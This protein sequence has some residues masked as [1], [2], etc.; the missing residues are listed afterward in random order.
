MNQR[1]LDEIEHLARQ[2]ETTIPGTRADFERIPSGGGW[3]DVHQNGRL[4]QL[5]YSPTWK[6]YCVDALHDDDAFQMNFRYTYPDFQPAAEQLLKMLKEA[7]GE[8]ATCNGQVQT[9]QGP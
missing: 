4:F 6:L 2:V 5:V 1:I 8:L 3:L 7:E 9:A